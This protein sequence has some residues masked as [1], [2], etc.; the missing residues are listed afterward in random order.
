MLGKVSVVGVMSCHMKL[1]YGS[2][3][4]SFPVLLRSC[5]HSLLLSWGYLTDKALQ[6]GKGTVLHS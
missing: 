6:G 4:N 5:L 3:V 1:R 2:L